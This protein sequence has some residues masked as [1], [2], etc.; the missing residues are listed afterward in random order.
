MKD[1]LN[2]LVNRGIGAF[3]VLMKCKVVSIII[4]LFT[5]VLH[6]I[7]PRGGLR[8]TVTM[9]SVFIALYALL[10]FICVLSGSNEKAEEGKKFASDMVK[11][12]FKGD[13][14]PLVKINEVLS[15]NE[16]YKNKMSNSAAKAK[17]D[18]RMQKLI[19]RHESQQ[20][21]SKVIMCIFY[22]VLF[23][24]AIMLFVWPDATISTVH[25][26][27]GALLIFDGFSGI[28]G[29]ISARKTG[30]PLKGKWASFFLNLLSVAI[31]LV[32]LFM[33]DD[34]ADFTMVLCGIVLVVKALSDLFIMIR[35]K[36]LISTV[37]EAVN[38]IKN[39]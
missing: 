8:G 14:N 15:Q 10:S 12:T 20:K 21:A 23:G 9:L 26:I 4:F 32:F 18:R 35:N 5:G 37:K 27:L 25:I 36:E 39:Q 7:D 1:K 31:G 3:G 13:G 6:I 2:V 11:D 22:V 33:S 17:W 30:I 28:W 38:E 24:A 29:I 19:Q 34:T 16:K